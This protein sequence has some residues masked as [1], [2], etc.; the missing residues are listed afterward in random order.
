[1]GAQNGS[2]KNH[3]A[4]IVIDWW[5]FFHNFIEILVIYNSDPVKKIV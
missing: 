3:G 4:I 1:M 2:Y 5:S